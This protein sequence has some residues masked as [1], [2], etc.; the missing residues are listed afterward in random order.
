MVRSNDLYKQI[1]AFV[2]SLATEKGYDKIGWG[3]PVITD[4]GHRSLSNIAAFVENYPIS[5]S[6]Q[7]GGGCATPCKFGSSAT[8]ECTGGGVPN[9][10]CGCSIL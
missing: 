10:G 4:L 5:V 3:I 8:G 7:G 6:G 2:E 9:T 1:S